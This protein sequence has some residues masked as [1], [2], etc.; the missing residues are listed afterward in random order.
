VEELLVPSMTITTDSSGFATL[1]L[2]R[3]SSS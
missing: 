2:L 3:I 1:N